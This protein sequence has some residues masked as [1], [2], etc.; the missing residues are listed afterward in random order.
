[1]GNKNYGPRGQDDPR[2]EGKP[3][4]KIDRQKKINKQKKVRKSLKN[5]RNKAIRDKKMEPILKGGKDPVMKS[6]GRVGRGMGVALKGGGSV[7]RK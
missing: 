5:I 1:M 3:K 2:E 6:G 7:T 4:K